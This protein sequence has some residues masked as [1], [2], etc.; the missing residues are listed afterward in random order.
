MNHSDFAFLLSDN[1]LL[2][3]SIF[4]VVISLYFLVFKKQFYSYLDPLFFTVITTSFSTT[5]VLFLFCLKAIDI[6]L[7]SSFIFSEMAFIFGFLAFGRIPLYFPIEN[8]SVIDRR[9][10]NSRPLIFFYFFILCVTII[11]VSITYYYFGIPLFSSSR[12][13][14]YSEGGGSGIFGRIIQVGTLAISYCWVVFTFYE[15]RK[16]LSLRFMNY[17]GIFF[18]IGTSV[19]SGSK[20]SFLGLFF[21]FSCTSFCLRK[22]FYEI[23]EEFNFKLKKI[24]LKTIPLLIAIGVSVLIVQTSLE[25]LNI[26]RAINDLAFRFVSTGDVFFMAYPAGVIDDIS[27]KIHDS[28]ILTVT[29]TDFFAMTRIVPWDDS[30]VPIGFLLTDYYYGP[31][32]FGPNARH[33]V[34]GYLYCGLLGGVIYSFM[35][36]LFVGFVRNYSYKIISGYLSGLVYVLFFSSALAIWGDPIYGFQ[37][38]NNIVFIIFPLLVLSILVHYVSN[39]NKSPDFRLF[40]RFDI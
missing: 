34:L 39:K 27:S 17:I 8:S 4:F 13:A 6:T 9:Q 28:N 31:E 11:S 24:F 22:F 2:Y 12:L 1:I 10:F 25:E 14:T 29:F 23:S 35:L 16:T 33:N 18:L 36:G 3:A 21:I 7:L 37:L 15:D 32:P 38:F 40:N 30:P 26:L 20:A 5:V 19:L